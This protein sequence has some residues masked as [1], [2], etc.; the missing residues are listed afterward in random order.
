MSFLIGKWHL[1]VSLNYSCFFYFHIIYVRV[2]CNLSVILSLLCSLYE[3]L[4]SNRI[5]S[6]LKGPSELQSQV[7]V[8][9]PQNTEPIH[10]LLVDHPMFGVASAG[11]TS[12]SVNSTEAMLS[13]RRS[14]TAVLRSATAAA[15]QEAQ[16]RP[17]HYRRRRRYRGSTPWYARASATHRRK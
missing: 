16:R 3:P 17:R 9:A 4:D 11:T 12:T 14:I 15:Q 6:P 2:I 1:V 5:S 7:Y 13:P 10:P 8:P